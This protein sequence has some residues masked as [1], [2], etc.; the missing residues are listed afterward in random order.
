MFFLEYTVLDLYTNFKMCLDQ[1]E[2]FGPIEPIEIA[3]PVLQTECPEL[4]IKYFG[5]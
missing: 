2:F 1:S 4:T 3:T 5:R